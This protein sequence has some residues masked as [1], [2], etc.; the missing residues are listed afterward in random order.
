[1][2]TKKCLNIGWRNEKTNT[3]RDK[4]KYIQKIWYL[5]KIKVVNETND[6]ARNF[7]SFIARVE[8]K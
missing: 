2:R 5:F 4:I 6:L 7:H 1:M 8:I 3:Q